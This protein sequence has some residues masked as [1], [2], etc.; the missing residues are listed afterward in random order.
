MNIRFNLMKFRKT[1]EKG[2]RSK[3]YFA[4]QLEITRQHYADLENGVSNPSFGLMIKF[5]KVFG[6]EFEDLWDLW[7]PMQ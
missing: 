7:K 4:E 2:R 1:R 5:E 6:N 3:T